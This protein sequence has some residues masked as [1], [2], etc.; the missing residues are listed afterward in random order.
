MTLNP[1]ETQSQKI[2]PAVL[3]YAFYESEIVMIKPHSTEGKPRKWNGLGGKLE[4]GETMRD[5]AVREFKEESQCTTAKHQWM[6]L[7]QLYFPNFKSSKNEDWWVTVFTT[8]LTTQQLREIPLN[9]SKLKEGV[10]KIMPL[11]KILTLDLWDGDQYFLPFVFAR[12]PFEGTFFY[13]NGQCTRHE[14]FPINGSC[15]PSKDQLP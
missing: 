2:I 11:S 6:W 3:L 8:D 13:E 15:S 14:I 1:Y 7:G 4:S 5:A 12:T 9:S 10:L